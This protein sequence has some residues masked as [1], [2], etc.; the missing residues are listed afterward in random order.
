MRRPGLRL[1][2]TAGFA[3]GALA[4]SATMAL[5]SYQI[6]RQSLLAER[7][8]TTIRSA[9]YD[10]A[11][12]RA[13]LAGTRPD[14]RE[15]LGS[16]D[17]GGNRRVV[18]QRSGT[19]YSRSADPGLTEAI[20]PALRERATAGNGI[21][22]QRVRVDG[23]AALVVAVPLSESAVLYEIDSWQELERTLQLLTVVLI[24]VALCTALFG[25]GLGWYA[26]R[27]VLRPL[28]RVADAAQEIAGGARQARLDPD[29]A[30]D[31]DRLT[32]SFNHMVDELSARMERDRRF[33]AD[34]SHEL[35]SPLQ[36]LAAAA[37]VL[38]RRRGQLDERTAVAAGLVVD[39]V[40]RFQGLVNDL[41]ELARSDQAADR[42]PVDIT[43]L[44]RQVCRAH[45]VDPA[46]V[47]AA[48]GATT[49]CIDRRRIAQLLGNLLDNATAY[50]GGA[51]AVHLRTAADR[52]IIEVDDEGPG[53]SPEDQPLIFDRF[54]RGRSAT[55]RANGAG[56]G[57]GLALVAQHAAA[58]HGTVVVQDRPGGGARFRVELGECLP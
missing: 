43:E 26:A 44:A 19:W 35:R 9:T 7:E 37:S 56:T 14:V 45:G 24:V 22:V 18:V 15:V 32:S 42:T 28:T 25:A 48:G 47:N 53:V 38:N 41:I 34:V 31:L 40:D 23:R 57:L 2:V 51:T 29:A 27:Y 12:V 16:L 36:T 54:V 55:A 1:R 52:G 49:W 50:G 39:E 58:H 3:A 5:V 46:L 21:A 17:T 8:R 20:P 11:V 13:G 4:L 10:A 6:T 30:P 33:A